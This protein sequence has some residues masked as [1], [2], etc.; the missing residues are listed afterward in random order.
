MDSIITGRGGW[1]RRRPTWESSVTGLCY[2]LGAIQPLRA[3]ARRPRPPAPPMLNPERLEL[4]RTILS[5]LEDWGTDARQVIALLALSAETK[6]RMLTR[7]GESLPL[8]DVAE[9]NER[10]EHLL[11]IAEALQTSYPLNRAA[12][13]L[14]LK[15]ANPRFD[16]RAP[17]ETMIDDG[18]NGL[19]AVRAHVDCAWDW[20]ESGSRRAP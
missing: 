14:W 19:R 8:P 10:I 2:D 6:P 1:H 3:K 18:L 5:V 7:Y 13:G 17:L 9:I 11:G 15:R 20:H 4:S 16:N 12:A